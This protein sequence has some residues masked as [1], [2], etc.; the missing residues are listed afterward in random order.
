[1][2]SYNLSPSSASGAVGKVLV[3]DDSEV[4]LARVAEHL[5]TAG[6][7]VITT[8]HLV[9]NARH[10]HTCDLV[11]IDFHMPG[12]TGDTVVA[13]LKSAAGSSGAHCMFL[14]YTSDPVVALKYAS[15]G[16]DGALFSK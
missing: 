3:I 11:I 15:F 4:I 2:S 6:F 9:G 5:T 16:F 10:L 13:S 8:T 14:L 12:M 1:M 7:E